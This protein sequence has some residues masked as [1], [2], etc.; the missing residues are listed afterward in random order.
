MT[1][2]NYKMVYWPGDQNSVADALS[3]KGKIC[4]NIPDKE[5]PAALFNPS[6]FIQLTLLAFVKGQ[7][8]LQEAH[9]ML[10]TLM[11]S[12]IIQ[13]ITKHLLN[14]DPTQWPRG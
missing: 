1:H 4:P 2:Y 7:P 12:E 8:K 10:T 13:Q 9:E 6:Q 14:L 11:D 5:K 3:C